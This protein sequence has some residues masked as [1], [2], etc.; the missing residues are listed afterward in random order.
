MEI[1]S[2]VHCEEKNT[3]KEMRNPRL[4]T[5]NPHLH[6]LAKC[7]KTNSSKVGILYDVNKNRMEGLANLIKSYF[8]PNKTEKRYQ[9]LNMKK[10]SA[11]FDVTL[12][13]RAGKVKERN[14]LQLIRLDRHFSEVKM[15]RDAK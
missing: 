7:V 11:H 3:R 8:I 10:I 15:G 13:Q 2:R 14:I 5:Q 6:L 9:M 12:Q 4:L 1:L